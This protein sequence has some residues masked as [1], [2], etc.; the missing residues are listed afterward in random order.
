MP[1][2]PRKPGSSA[3]RQ[4]RSPPISH[5]AVSTGASSISG[6]ARIL[7]TTQSA[8][9]QAGAAPVSFPASTRR[10]CAARCRAVAVQRL[11]IDVD[12]DGVRGAEL[13]GGDAQDSGAAA[14]I[15]HRAAGEVQRVQH[16]Q[17]Q[18]GRRMRAGAERQPGIEPHDHGIGSSGASASVG[19]HPQ[20]PPE[21]H[22]LP[23]G[24]PDAFP[25]ARLRRRVIRAVAA[26]CGPSRRRP[27]RPMATQSVV[28]IVEQRAHQRVAPQPDL[29][30]LGFEH[31][32]VAAVDEA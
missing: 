32:I 16:L 29:A 10:R 2:S 17:A 8:R 12:G 22:G 24:K 11:R 27:D 7:A 5:A 23:V 15:D 9:R 21:A 6:S 25:I 31:R 20:P 30:R 28:R 26:M 3:A 18:R 13:Q 1:L 4:I 19:A 14:V